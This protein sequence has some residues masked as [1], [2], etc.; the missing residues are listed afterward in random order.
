MKRVTVARTLSAPYVPASPTAL[1][2]SVGASRF[3][4]FGVV[5]VSHRSCDLRTM[6][7]IAPHRDALESVSLRLRQAGFS[8]IVLLATCNR[9]EVLYRAPGGASDADAARVLAALGAPAEFAE[10]C[11]HYSGTGALAHLCE[12]AASIDSLVVG[13]SQ[14]AGQLRGATARAELWGTFGPLLRRVT[15][16]AFRIARRVRRDA[17]LVRGASVA[18]LAVDRV[19]SSAAARSRATLRVA[20]IGAGEMTEQ[21]AL[22]LSKRCNAQIIF[23]NRTLEKA[24]SLAQRFAGSAMPLSQFLADPPPVDAMVTSTAAP[25][26]IFD[27]A[28]IDRLQAAR[29]AGAPLAVV[30][31]AVPFD[32]AESQHGRHDLEIST[33]E[34]LRALAAARA[35]EQAA[36]VERARA[37][38]SERL[39]ALAARERAREA[40]R[41]LAQRRSLA[42]SEARA[43]AAALAGEGAV[44]E[45]LERWAV[46]ASHRFAHLR[47]VGSPCEGVRMLATHALWASEM[48][49][50]API[51][52]QLSPARRDGSG[53]WGRATL[54]TLTQTFELPSPAR[55][56]R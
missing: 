28:A 4:E 48:R 51:A 5:G 6:A 37:L 32:V 38:I 18:S 1:G 56:A 54:A 20:L 50:L 42:E 53:A 29:G 34:D 39:E 47:F 23:V 46:E 14:I 2:S 44:S 26:A 40:A 9:F 3:V 31:L 52:R 30:D 8:E 45:R 55:S 36:E 22:L 17:H 11:F 13:E 41:T 24:Q 15:T 19:L 10:N 35:A 12:V 25:Q 49:R 7:R 21:T 33:M 16:E 27:G 43:A